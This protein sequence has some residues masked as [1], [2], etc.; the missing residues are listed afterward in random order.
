MFSTMDNAYH[1]YLIE[2]V[3]KEEK[4]FQHETLARQCSEKGKPIPLPEA[5]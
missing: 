1:Y 2:N 5:T 3:T 4:I